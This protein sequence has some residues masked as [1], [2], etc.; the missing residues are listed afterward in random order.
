[1]LAGLLKLAQGGLNFTVANAVHKFKVRLERVEL[2]CSGLEK[3][4][5]AA[6]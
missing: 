5:K 4:L 6:C 3:V 1:M 2:V